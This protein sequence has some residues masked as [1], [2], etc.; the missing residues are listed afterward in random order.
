MVRVQ[1]DLAVLL[2]KPSDWRESCSREACLLGQL[3]KRQNQPYEALRQS[4][5]QFG[6]GLGI[7]K[8]LLFGP[9]RRRIRR[10]RCSR[11]LDA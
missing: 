4:W 2:K 3:G 11:R 1:S 6:Q 7:H 5:S 8:V 10:R 9:A